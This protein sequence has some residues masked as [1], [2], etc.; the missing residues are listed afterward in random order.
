MK[1][2]FSLEK[3]RQ[4]LAKKSN[5]DELKKTYSSKLPEILDLNKRTF[6][7]ERLK[8]N[9]SLYLQDGM[10]QDRIINTAKIIPKDSSRILDIGIGYGFVE[11]LIK[12]RNHILYGIDISDTAVANLK[13]R[14]KGHFFVQSIYKLTFKKKFFDVV[15]ALEV[16]EHIPPS[17]ILKVLSSIKKILK[18]NGVL[19]ISVPT[20]EGLENMKENIN[21]HTRMYTYDLIKSELILSGFKVNKARHFYAFKTNYKVKKILAK[22]LKKKWQPN[23]ILIEA[24][25]FSK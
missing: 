4:S 1:N 11:E 25:K 24:K 5:L 13:K 9:P 23:N 20:N 14:L 21:G 8:G 7:N 22:V 12:N 15:M 16:L 6:W 18:D 10:T 2:G 19:I 17:K 3:Y